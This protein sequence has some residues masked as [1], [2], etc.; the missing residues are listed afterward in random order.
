MEKNRLSKAPN[1]FSLWMAAGQDEEIIAI[2]N[3]MESLVD[4]M[5]NTRSLIL[6]QK[7]EKY[8]II[9]VTHMCVRSIFIG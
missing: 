1:Y 7:L 8:P 2:N 6:L 4:E 3:R 5:S 9:P